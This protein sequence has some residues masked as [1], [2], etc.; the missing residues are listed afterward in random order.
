MLSYVR[1]RF[2]QIGVTA[3]LLAYLKEKGDVL[4]QSNY[5]GL[6]LTDHVLKV[7]EKVVKNIICDI[8]KIEEMQFG[9]CPGRGTTDAIFILRQLQE[10]CLTKH[11]KLY[12]AFVDLEKSL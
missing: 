9:L 6:K 4:D 3:S 10:K 1:E 2:L 11:R 12:M 5:C 8:V 7:I